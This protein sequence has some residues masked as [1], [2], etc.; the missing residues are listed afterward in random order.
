MKKILKNGLFAI[1]LTILFASAT[2][3]V[4]AASSITVDSKHYIWYE[5]QRQT[6]FHTTK[7]Y[8]YCITPNREGP[9]EGRTLTYKSKV[10]SGGVLY[11]IDKYN[12]T[13]D[14]EY[15]AT[16]LAVWLYDSN[17]MSE[18]WRD[19]GNLDVVKRAKA[20]A[21][22]ASKNSNY[23]HTPSVSLSAS[24]VNL[25]ITSDNKYYRSAAIKV[26]MVNATTDATLAVIDGPAGVQIVDK[27]YKSITKISNGGVFYIQ[28]PEEK[29]TTTHSFRIRATVTGKV[30]EFERYTTG[31][32]NI[33][34]LIVLVKTDKTVNTSLTVKVTPVK[35]SCEQ[36]N[37]KY[38]NKEGKVV[39]KNTYIIE[40]DK[41]SCSK[42]GDKYLGIDG[43]VITYDEYVTQ[44]L[45]PTCE[46]VGE[47]YYGPSGKVIT[48][49]EFVIQCKKPTCSRVGDK[50]L[51]KDGTEVSHDEYLLQCNQP[52]TPLPDGRYIGKEGKFVTHD[53]YIIQCEKPTC[54][55]VGDKYLGKDGTEVSYEEYIVQCQSPICK[56]V[57]GMYF[58][59]NGTRVTEAE[60]KAQCAV[61]VPDTASSMLTELLYLIIGSV[62]LGTSIGIITYKR[63]A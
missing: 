52:C 28:M 15:L 51:G 25:A 37:G 40:C 19:H 14:S 8:A 23:T 54:K 5:D 3:I 55:K 10:S 16:Q 30:A 22:E 36:V 43:S 63:N 26:S 2:Q 34:E 24:D 49:E 59:T 35:R 33:Q 46:Q 48:Y 60:Y 57:D 29:V 45:K 18:Y 20:L 9:A 11:L 47:K 21:A 17:H 27:N 1:I 38:Y 7:G 6:K 56:V 50:Y 39:D 53:E 13:S 12:G 31:N 32:S 42:V 62:I 58:G 44:C 4:H 41:P 61:P